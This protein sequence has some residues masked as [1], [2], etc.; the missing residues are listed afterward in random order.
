VRRESLERMIDKAK[1]MGAKVVIAADFET[2]DIF[3]GTPALFW[4]MALQLS[5][6]QPKTQ[7]NR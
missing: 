7:H 6:S 3:H 5:L 4:L 1:A 2:S